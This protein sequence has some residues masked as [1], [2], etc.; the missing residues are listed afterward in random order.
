MQKQNIVILHTK[1]LLGLLASYCVYS[2]ERCDY[3]LHRDYG[4]VFQ[5]STTYRGEATYSCQTGYVI[6]GS[7][8]RTCQ[9]DG[10]WSGQE[11][12]CY[13]KKQC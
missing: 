12:N 13:G 8:H 1:E 9:I 6:N 11:P 7:D 5:T 2:V 3:L 10:T 4:S